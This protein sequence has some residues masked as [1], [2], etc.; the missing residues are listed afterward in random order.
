MAFLSS[1]SLWL[2]RPFITAFLALKVCF[3]LHE[4]P[5]ALGFFGKEVSSDLPQERKGKGRRIREWGKRQ[6]YESLKSFWVLH[7][8]Q[9]SLYGLIIYWLQ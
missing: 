8:A 7:G 1:L 9:V 5:K 6:Q 4:K 3:H 2:W